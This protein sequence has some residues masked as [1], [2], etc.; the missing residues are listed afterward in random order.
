MKKVQKTIS[1]CINVD[2]WIS[3]FDVELT[4]TLLTQ[5]WL[6]MKHAAHTDLYASG[7]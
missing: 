6:T 4:R 7:K 1:E 5:R 2:F 3:V